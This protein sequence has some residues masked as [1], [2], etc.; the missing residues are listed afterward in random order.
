MRHFGRKSL[1]VNG[2]LLVA[3]RTLRADKST[4]EGETSPSIRPNFFKAVGVAF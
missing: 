1:L 3:L 2:N 4:Q